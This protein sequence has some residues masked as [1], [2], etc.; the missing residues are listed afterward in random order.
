MENQPKGPLQESPGEAN[1]AGKVEE[2]PRGTGLHFRFDAE[3]RAVLAGGAPPA[4]A[5]PID[6]DW[7]RER[8]GQLGYGALR[9][10]P[11]TARVLISQYNSGAAVAALRVAECVDAEFSVTLSAD[12]LSALLDI[13]PA[14]GGNAVTEAAI[15]GRMAA[16]GISDG[17]DVEAIREAIRAGACVGVVVARGR[18]PVDGADGWLE[19]LLPDARDRTPTI[20]E[21]GRVDYRELGDI[22]VVA[23]GDPLMRRHPP[24]EGRF[25]LDLLGLPIPAYSG[26]NVNFAGAL[27]GAAISPDDPDLLVAT[28]TGLPVAVTDGMIVEPVYV[29]PEVGPASGNI[30]FDG[31]V[32]IRGDVIAGMTVSVSGDIEVE[33]MVEAATLEA[34]GSI[35]VKGG[36]VGGLGRKDGGDHTIRCGG[37]FN[38]AYAQQARIEAGDSIFIDDIAMQCDLTAVNHIL[39]GNRRRGQIIGGRAQATL[40][41]K[42]KVLGSPNHMVTRFEIGVDPG[43]LKQVHELANQRDAKETQ[44]LE[45]SK[46][47]DF[48][49][50]NPQRIP[51]ETLERARTT[52]AGLSAE[53]ATLRET[54]QALTTKI[55]LAQQSCVIGTQAMYEGVDVTMGA[56]RHRLYGDHGAGANALGNGTHGPRGLDEVK[57]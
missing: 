2:I 31:S 41:V 10:S 8:I 51:P 22:V 38:A 47:L 19:K 36:V 9:Y 28:A 29:V 24:T 57:A 11:V 34:G 53:I 14:Q 37:S 45:V 50:H 25:G 13:V 33:G 4:G 46:L 1:D 52:A 43:L 42:A 21:S 5:A 7:L 15:L 48:A 35:V 56:F 17:I 12:C 20:D 55:E 32:V 54:Q 44:L 26:K 30:R 27:Q 23:A 39:V 49:A 16:Q 6:E 40:S 18:L 3:T